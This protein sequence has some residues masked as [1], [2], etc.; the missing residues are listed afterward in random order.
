MPDASRSTSFSLRLVFRLALNIGLVY[1]FAT[2][3]SVFFVLEGGIKA[4]VLVSVVLTIINTIVVPLLHILSLP[5]KLFAWIVAFF[6]V[7]A[8]ALYL[9]VEAIRIL[10]VPGISLEVAGG[11]A[12]WLTLSL[13]LGLG[14]WVVRAVLK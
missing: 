6:L 2:K 8:A 1:L 12:G 5:I 11:V 7:N 3:F 14:N 13:I 4:I 9:A 10:A